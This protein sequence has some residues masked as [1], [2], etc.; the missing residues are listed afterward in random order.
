MASISAA[1]I[2][3]GS[4]PYARNDNFCA[5]IRYEDGSVCTLTYTALGPKTGLAKERIEVF[6]DGEAWIVDDFK[7]LTRASDGS[8]LWPSS[9]PTRVTSR[10]CAGLAMPGRREREPDPYPS[11]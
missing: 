4:M 5:T 7:S 8:V 9:T 2:D 11:S 10:R 1:A 3:P 6:C